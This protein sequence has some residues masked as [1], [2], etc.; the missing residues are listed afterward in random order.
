MPVASRC[1][2]GG[3]RQQGVG[4]VD[5][6]VDDR[7]AVVIGPAGVPGRAGLRRMEALVGHRCEDVLAE[8]Q[9]VETELLGGL[10]Q[11]DERRDRQVVAA[12]PDTHDCHPSTV[13]G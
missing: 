7:T 5:A 10:A 11:L 2:H 8:P 13:C 9:A 3:Q 6:R 1:A 12:D 4:Q